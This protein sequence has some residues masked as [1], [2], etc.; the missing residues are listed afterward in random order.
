M[1][2][3]KVVQLNEVVEDTVGELVCLV[4]DKEWAIHPK[5]LIHTI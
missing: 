5:E 2:R 1:L 3:Q 4:E